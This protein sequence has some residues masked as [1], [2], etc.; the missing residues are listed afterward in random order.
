MG[1]PFIRTARDHC[2]SIGPGDRGVVGDLRHVTLGH[3]AFRGDREVPYD[4]GTTRVRHGV[5]QPGAERQA[6][7]RHRGRPRSAP[8]SAERTGTARR[9]WPGSTARRD[10]MSSGGG[11]PERGRHPGGGRRARP[12]RHPATEPHLGRRPRGAEHRDHETQRAETEHEPVRVEPDVQIE[13]AGQRDREAGRERDRRDQR[14]H[15]ADGRGHERRRHHR[16]HHDAAVRADGPPGREIRGSGPHGP[17]ERLPDQRAGADDHREREEQQPVPFDLRHI[18]DL[19]DTEQCGARSP[20]SPGDR[21]PSA[22]RL[23]TSRSPLGRG[24]A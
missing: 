5:G 8:T 11:R 3:G 24:R 10:P 1:L 20:R 7:R 18:A 19:R 13:V 22:R 21:P 9:P 12:S 14:R 23:G 2:A 6:R 15:D 16:P 17:H 4:S